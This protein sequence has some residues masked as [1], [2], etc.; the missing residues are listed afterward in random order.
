MH[1]RPSLIV[2]VPLLIAILSFGCSVAGPSES[3]PHDTPGT[4]TPYGTLSFHIND[5][6]SVEIPGEKTG[7]L[8][9]L[10]NGQETL[11]LP[12]LD[13]N[14]YE[15]PVFNGL[16]CLDD[17]GRGTW[18]DVL[19]PGES[20]YQVNCSWAP[21]TAT[22]GLSGAPDSTLWRLAFGTEDPWFGDLV[23]RVDSEGRAEGTIETAT[24]DFRF[25]HGSI[26]AGQLILQTFD[27]A[28]LFRFSGE[29]GNGQIAN[30]WFS[31]GNHYGTPFT[32]A[33]LDEADTPLSE[34]QQAEWTGAAIEFSGKDLYGNDRSW[35]WSD[36]QDSIHVLSIMG[37]W[38]PN[39]LDEHRLL[40]ELMSEFPRMQ[41]H[42][43]AFER[44]LDQ[45]NG[46]K[47]A[48]RRLKQ[49]HE[50]LELWRYEG[51][52]DVTLVGPASKSEARRLLPFVDRVVSFPTTVVLHPAAPQPWIHSGFNGPATGAKYELER[53]AL[54]AA[55][56]GRLESH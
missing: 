22:T 11:Q 49:Y 17:S 48:L 6:I 28:H 39:C 50:Q 44:G 12:A 34:G 13:S 27:G 51:R 25:L 36:A 55:L 10:R 30:G 53:S 35:S 23:I 14:C 54:A 1:T 16:I 42:T 8:L 20:P 37:S 3:D 45:S 41:V 19:R 31:S 15:V 9:T 46:E 26:K 33:F 43:L 4:S 52:W 18:T 21:G 5:S 47:L 29:V 40:H 24:G 38:C 2:P 56:S 32:G 7:R